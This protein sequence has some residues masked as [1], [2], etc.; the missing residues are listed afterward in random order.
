VVTVSVK[1]DSKAKFLAGLKR[2][3]KKT[4]QTMRDAFLEQAALACQDAATFTPPLAKGGGKGL[5]KAAE[6]AGEDAVGGDIKKIYVSAND[7]YS[8]NAANVLA[9][10]L[11]YATRNND[12]GTF[13]KLIGSGSMKALKSLSPIMQKIAND[14][15]YDRAFRKAKNY[16]NRAN[17]VLSDYGTIGYVFN[18]KPVHN[19]IK[20]KF[21]GRIKRKVKPVKKKLLVETTAELKEYIK[22]RQMKVGSIKSG[23]ASA[24]RSLPP[25]MIN[26]IPKNFGTDL[27]NVAWINRHTNIAGQ[28]SVWSDDK[29]VKIS[30]RNTMGN[31]SGIATDANVLQLVYANRVKQMRA[32]V[33]FHLKN[34]IAE[35]NGK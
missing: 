21:G 12:I 18:L 10:N 11:A 31:I 3:A 28:S 15:D 26:G 6:I 17:I 16:L 7:R 35:E 25:P 14:M 5:S 23:W 20:A 9:T 1:P 34:T 27:L 19:E 22:E 32:R 33:K 29:N 2:F 8:K 4:G 30:I 24:L 13:N